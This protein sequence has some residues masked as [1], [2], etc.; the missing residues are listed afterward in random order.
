MFLADTA[1]ETTG[2][3][4]VRLVA[5][6]CSTG[7]MLPAALLRH[8]G[9]SREFPVSVRAVIKSV[10]SDLGALGDRH[11]PRGKVGDS[12]TFLLA[13]Q[14]GRRAA[15][16]QNSLARTC[17]GVYRFPPIYL[18]VYAIYLGHN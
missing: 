9:A 10:V 12:P 1:L 17:G 5:G 15:A 4:V 14:F 11:R 2:N 8:Y 6:C 18:V 13:M 16:Q 7:G 3:P